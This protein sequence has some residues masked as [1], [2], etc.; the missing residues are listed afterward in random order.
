MKKSALSTAAALVCML[1]L[2]ITA[3]ADIIHG[4]AEGFGGA[5]SFEGGIQ[6]GQIY[7]KAHGTR[8]FTE[9]V[10]VIQDN[11]IIAAYIDD[12]QFMP[13]GAGAIGVPNSDKDFA[14][15]YAKGVVLISKRTNADYYSGLMR[16]GAG[17]TVPINLNYDA[18]QSFVIGKT[19][20]EVEAAAGKNNA[21]DAV[22]G[23][24]LEDTA[25]YLKAIADAAR[26]AKQTQAVEYKGDSGKLKLNVLLGAA[27]GTKCFTSAA[28]VTDGDKIILCW[29]D[30]FQFL[31]AVSDV[32]GVPNS[33]SDFGKG[34]TNGVVLA[35]K[36]VN[37]NY[38]SALMKKGAGAT[39]RIDENYNAIQAKLD[40]MKISD[41]ENFV[42]QDNVIDA[43]SGATLADTANYIRLIIEAAKF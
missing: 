18:I 36:R 9:A 11:T 29:I 14:D 27:H 12:Y 4:E 40:G 20:E 1:A 19:I 32:T 43:V 34:Y 39:V 8:C 22:S 41:A 23:A 5:V 35:S 33:S 7:T 10:A 30:D 28:V 15:G 24:T 3:E 25:N 6:I 16:K 21:V 38:Y 37:A 13:A 31:P 2:T 42:K 26:A 17:A